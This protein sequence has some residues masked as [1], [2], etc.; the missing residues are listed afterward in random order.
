MNTI[1]DIFLQMEKAILNFAHICDMAFLSKDGKLN[2]IGIFERLNIVKFPV[3]QPKITFVMNLNLQEGEYPFKIRLVHVASNKEVAKME[4]KINC[5]KKGKTGLINEFI[6]TVFPEPGEYA[7]EIWINDEPTGKV[8]FS[9][10][11]VH[12]K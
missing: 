10:H 6:D 7:V 12:K 4:G 9:L 1:S 11:H 2:I 5:K 3:R 8:G